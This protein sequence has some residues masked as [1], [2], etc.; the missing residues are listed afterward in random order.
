[1]T[2]GKVALIA[3]ICGFVAGMVTM[4]TVLDMVR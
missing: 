3:W 4:T 1:M 2:V